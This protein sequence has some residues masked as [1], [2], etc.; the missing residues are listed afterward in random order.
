MGTRLYEVLMGGHVHLVE[1]AHQRQAIGHV[2]KGK[3]T[4]RVVTALE[5]VKMSA[6]GH[7]V[8]VA[9]GKVDGETND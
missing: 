7:K 5:A 8:E 6:E 3:V 4:A 9:G 2:V 1:A